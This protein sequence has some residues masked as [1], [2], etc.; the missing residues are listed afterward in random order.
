MKPRK[1]IKRSPLPRRKKPIP[2]KNPVRLAR[3]RKAYTAF[4]RSKAWREQRQRVLERDGGECQA[5]VKCVWPNG[6]A[7][8]RGCRSTTSPTIHHLKYSP[9]GIE[10]TPD[11]DLI[12]LCRFHHNELHALEGKRIAGV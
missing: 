1:P 6:Q 8:L 3:R 7:I 2:K 12:T 11:K 4:L 5:I 9:R 10:H